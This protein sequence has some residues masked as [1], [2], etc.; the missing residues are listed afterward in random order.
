MSNL[1]IN[2]YFSHWFKSRRINPSPARQQQI[3]KRW[4]PPPNGVL[5]INS[6]AK[7]NADKKIALAGIILRNDQGVMLGGLTKKS[8]VFSPIIAEALAV[9]EA[10]AFAINCNMGKVLIETDCKELVR[11]CKQE[12]KVGEIMALVQDIENLRNNNPDIGLTWTPREGN[13]AAHH[14]AL[15]GSRNALP[16]IWTSVPPPSL[17]QII[18]LDKE[19]IL[20]RPAQ[21]NGYEGN[22]VNVVFSDSD[23]HLCS[24][25]VFPF[26]PGPSFVFGASPSSTA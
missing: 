8:P 23:A 17:K 14:V 4:R 19:R 20:D 6:D 10:L 13:V 21:R 18:D 12:I 22:V 2:D 7:F 25:R 26:D 9:R 5:K 16:A 11:A 1:L 3:N 24:D 15:L